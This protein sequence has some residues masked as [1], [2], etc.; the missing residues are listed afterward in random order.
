MTYICNYC[1]KRF[2]YFR[3]LM[4]GSDDL[5]ACPYCGSD[6]WRHITEDEDEDD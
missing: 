3:L 6:D 4:R 5:Q 2:N 1:R